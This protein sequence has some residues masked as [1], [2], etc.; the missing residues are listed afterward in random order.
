MESRTLGR[1][2]LKVGA[3][4]LG[5][6]HLLRDASNMDAVLASA[7]EAGANY[8]DLLY[9]DPQ[10]GDAGFWAPFGP[11]LRAR[12]DR[13]VLAAHWGSGE[14]WEIE[15]CRR[16]FDDVLA[17][18]GDGYAEVGM[19]TMVDD[20]AKWDPW[21]LQSIEILQRYREQGRIGHIGLSCHVPW[22]ATKII[23]SGQI[24]VLMYNVNLVHAAA[25]PFQAVLR[26]VL[27]GTSGWR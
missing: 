22:M 17:E 27:N 14:T 11:A 8:I 16:R 5:T 25:P 6:E 10:G 24:D 15:R 26:P 9:P 19:V 2:G 23:E 20:E 12:R 3:I 7:G 13:F 21:A 4:G 18:T 1:T